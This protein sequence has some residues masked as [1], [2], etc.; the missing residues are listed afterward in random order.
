MKNHISF[1]KCMLLAVL[2]M[3]IPS[4]LADAVAVSTPSPLVPPNIITNANRPMMMLVTSKDHT[5][6]SPVYTDFE[7]IDGDD[8]TDTTYLPTFKYYGYFDSTK[9]YAYSTSNGR[10]EPNSLA[11]TS[12]TYTNTVSIT[13]QGYSCLANT[14]R[15]S[16]NFLNWATMTRLD[17]VRKLLYGGKRSTDTS[18]ATVLERAPLSMDSHGFV[19]YYKGL[20]IEHF[21]PF[22]TTALTKTTGSNANSYAGLSICNR[23]NTDG[24][25]GTPLM[26]LAKGN[27]KLWAT[28]EGQACQWGPGSAA[29]TA[30][31]GGQLGPKLK[32]YYTFGLLKT[33]DA[34]PLPSRQPVNIQN[35]APTGSTHEVNRPSTNSDG[36]LG[37]ASELTV[38]VAVCVTSLLDNKYCHSYAS[39]YKPIGLLQEFGLPSESSTTA[40]TEFGL[41]SGSYDQNLTAGALRRNIG[42]LRDEVNTSTGV[43]CHSASSGCTTLADTRTTGTGAIKAMDNIVLYGKST[44][45][46]AGTSTLLPSELTDGVFPAWGN[47]IGE[48][49]VQALQYYAGLSSTNPTSTTNDTNKG[50]PVSSWRDPLGETGTINAARKTLYGR[51]ICR[52]LN[53]LALSSSALSFDQSADSPFETLPNRGAKTLANFTDTIGSLEGIIGTS[54]SAA[55]TS[56]SLS[57]ADTAATGC[58]AKNID[59]LSSVFGIC[60]EAPN[61]AGTYKVAGAAFYANTHRV[62]DTSSMTLPT[63]LPTTALK[64]KTYAAA[65]TGGAPVIRVN[66]PSNGSNSAYAGKTVYITPEALGVMSDRTGVRMPM[67]VLTFD[68]IAASKTGELPWGSFLVTWNNRTFGGDYDMD[69]AGFL[70]YDVIATTTGALSGYDLKISTDIVNVGMGSMGTYGFSV[71][72]TNNDGRQLTHRTQLGTSD[73]ILL[74]HGGTPLAAGYLCGNAAYLAANNSATGAACNVSKDSNTVYTAPYLK[75]TNF[76]MIGGNE[77]LEDPLWYAAK[78]GSFDSSNYTSGTLNVTTYDSVKTDGSSGQD[79]TPDGYF[80]ARR[81]DLLEDQLRRALDSLT[82]DSNAAPTTTAGNLTDN[83]IKYKATFDSSTVTG[84]IEAYKLL[85]DQNG[86]PTDIFASS[87][88]LSAGQILRIRTSGTNGTSG[89]KGASRAIITNYGNKSS[90]N[91]VPGWAFRWEDLASPTLPTGYQALLTTASTNTLSTTNAQRLVQYMRGDQSLEKFTAGL[92]VRGDNMLGPIVNATPW[93]HSAPAAYFLETQSPGYRA[94]VTA[95]KDRPSLLWVAANDGMLHAFNP[96][97]LTETFAYVPGMIANRLAEIPLQRGGT[98]RT[99]VSTTSGGA[100]T[101]SNFTSGTT[102]VQPEGTVWAY[103]DGNPFTADI[104]LGITTDSSTGVENGGTWATYLFSALGRGGRG[105]FALDVT[106]AAN[107]TS[108]TS[109]NEGNANSIFKWQF[110]AD[111][112]IQTGETV[113]D[114]GYIVGDIG[115]NINSGQANPIV[116]LNNGK[117]G[118]LL[119]NGPKSASGKAVLY[120]LFVDGPDASTG[121]WSRITSSTPT[122]QYVKIVAAQA[123]TDGTKNG[124]STPLWIDRD[125]NGTADVVYAGDLKGNMWKFDISSSSASD[126]KVAYKTGAGVNR[127]LFTAQYSTTVNGTITTKSLPITAAP[128]YVYPA[129]DGLIINFGT[130]NAF[131]TGDFPMDGVQQRFYGLWDRPAFATSS[132]T[133][134]G[135]LIPTSLTTLVQRNYSRDASTGNVTV[136]ANST[137]SLGNAIFTSIDWTSQDGWY[138]NLPG[139][140]EAVLST[141]D[142]QAGFLIFTSVRPKT[143]IESCNN[144]PNS[145]LYAIDPIAGRNTRTGLKDETGAVF[146]GIATADQKWITVNNTTTA[147][148]SNKTCTTGTAGCVEGNSQGDASGDQVC[149]SLINNGGKTN[150]CYN[151]LGRV[152]WR[153]IPGLRTT[154]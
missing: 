25:G 67:S 39:A 75:T 115:S 131:E 21:T 60:P 1:V 59:S 15:W 46:Y 29:N 37:S 53:V 58:S 9:C 132:D 107:A 45:S 130:G 23:S 151:P 104:K 7:D 124:L 36:A 27:Y 34:F 70:R 22:T 35:L 140:S 62:R 52:P 154:Q 106:G 153:E 16:G 112:D 137:D 68:A 14:G 102:E 147:I 149:K 94:F 10:F 139:T 40:R 109:L 143:D 144:T 96:V 76:Q 138:F 81:P 12:Y 18:T 13:V 85:L 119:N 19:K 135:P 6:F 65:L 87:P 145:T 95:H 120:L 105:V 141:P 108:W 33:N 3:P 17:V 51:N 121:K 89:D 103:V 110:T 66:I 47:P 32:D 117:F 98:G 50:L 55:A 146:A 97:D 20:D 126:W 92:R 123:P 82:K 49:V 148:S 114:L 91:T 24:E 61:T 80:L 113:S 84:N 48:M 71:I 101:T 93:L 69:V 73:T 63:D 150:L 134:T 2:C 142:L 127:P 77:T 122:G 57:D 38:R 133:G 11:A 129:F 116:K 86:K 128:E 111:D 8:A 5:L 56:G 152:Q 78:Y 41:I 99:Y 79:G 44:S 43:F 88:F 74:A 125:N 31:G 136:T 42:D 64:V 72:G 4:A 54:R 118:L 30:S 100:T 90:S 28:V 26:L 83:S